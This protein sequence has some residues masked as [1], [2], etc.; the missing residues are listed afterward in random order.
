MSKSKFKVNNGYI[1][2]ACNIVFNTKNVYETDWYVGLKESHKYYLGV[3]NIKKYGKILREITKEDVFRFRLNTLIAHDYNR[4]A[5]RIN[6]EY[7]IMIWNLEDCFDL[8][9]IEFLSCIK[10]MM[11]SYDRSDVQLSANIKRQ[12]TALRKMLPIWDTMMKKDK[13]SLIYIGNNTRLDA[14]H[15]LNNSIKNRYIKL[16]DCYW[17]CI[18]IDECIKDNQVTAYYLRKKRGEDE[19][20]VETCGK[21]KIFIH[22]VL[23]DFNVN[24]MTIRELE[25][26]YGKPVGRK[27]LVDKENAVNYDYF[28][29]HIAIIKEWDNV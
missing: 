25:A 15:S 18:D 5:I 24:G 12:M 29:K 7:S 13:G 6:N 17:N 2:P 21:I 23:M 11:K 10:A 22:P 14:I 9:P 16:E 19:Y 4:Y 1:I 26:Q 27:K 20:N 28:V 3:Y 8:S